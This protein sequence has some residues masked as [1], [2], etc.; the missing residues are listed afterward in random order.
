MKFER[1]ALD[2]RYR[3]DGRPFYLNGTQALVRLTMLE[4][5]RR[6]AQGVHTA[7]YASGYRGSPLGG[8]DQAMVRAKTFL[9]P[10]IV[11]QPGVNEDIAAT[12]IWG[13]QQVGVFGEARYDGVSALWYGKGPGVDRT[14]DVFKHGNLAGSSAQGGVLVVAGDDHTAKSSTT[15]HQSEFGLIDA[16][17]PILAPASIA[18]IMEYGLIGWELSRFTGLWCAIKVVTDVMDSSASITADPAPALVRPKIE[19]PPG[20]LSLRWP[21]D[22]LEQE[23]RL[24]RYKLPAALAFAR[25]NRLDRVII[26]APAAKLGIVTVGKAHTDT[27]QALRDLGIDEAR[28]AALGVR[29]YKV[30]MAWPLEPQGVRAFAEGLDQIVVV[31]EKRSLVEDQL[32]QH[33]YGAARP[34]LIVGKH[35]E[36]G[37]W[38]LPSNGDL[39]AKQIAAAIGPRI[40]ALRP[41]EDLAARLADLAAKTTAA[42][43]LDTILTRAP[44][45][46]P[47]CP[48]STSTKLPEGS[49]GFAGIGCHHLALP[50]ERGT[51]GFTHMGGEG[52]N[53]IGLSPFT[54]TPHT[55][56]NLGDGTYFH[57]GSLAIRAAVA[58]KVNITY[59]ILFNGAVAMTGG[60][61][62]DGDLTPAR[63]ARQML[64]EG[65]RQVVVVSDDPERTAA[66]VFEPG[67]RIVH[68]RELDAVQRELR[69][70]TGVT[71]LIYDQGCATELRRQRKRG[72]AVDP[73]V[74]VVIN[75]LVCE[76]CGDCS[77]QSSCLSVTPVETEF[78]R[79]RAIDLSTCNKDRSCL[80]GFCP[81]FVTVEGGR[82]RKPAV[83]AVEAA[84]LPEPQVGELDRPFSIMVTGIGGSGVVTVGA[85]LGFAAHMEGKAVH[86]MD[87]TGLA[88]KG[89]AVVSHVQLAPAGTVEPSAKIGAGSAD[90]LLACDTVVAATPDNLSRVARSA[91][92]VAN[93]HETIT[94]DFIRNPEFAV[95]R[96]RLQR[97]LAAAVESGAAVFFDAA[98]LAARLMG[99]AA[100]AALLMLGY[101]WQRGWLP[102]GWDALDRAIE[103]NGVAVAANRSAFAW[104]RRAAVD[105]PAVL[106]MA[107]AAR[108]SPPQ[109]RL[110]GST[111]ELVARRAGML[112]AYQDAAYARRYLAAVRRVE[113]AEASI[114]PGS[115][116]LTE[117]AAR[118]LFQLMA[119]KD[120]YEVARLYT[121]TGFLDG[122]KAQFEGSFRLRFHMAPPVLSRIDKATGR[123][124]K[125]TFG[126]AMIPLLRTLALAR[127]LRGT[128]LDVFGY[129]AERR[130][131]REAIDRY[132]AVLDEIVATLA[133]D[134]LEAA[135]RLAEAAQAIKGY[136]HVK[137]RNRDVAYAREAELLTAYRRQSNRAQDRVP[138]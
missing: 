71:V 46:C 8:F 122:L 84:A 6:Q 73:D 37:A 64:A 105:L 128:S 34:P 82:L 98:D 112:T 4:L 51:E 116:R 42:G 32:R 120:E 31:E 55:F 117:A 26:D 59:K 123:P 102:L 45:F 135:V 60:Q 50:M 93:S 89:G 61:A 126:P 69:E 16:S 47:G 63:I 20:A 23:A 92:I 62:M 113:A 10:D 88:Q 72:K 106:R 49:I 104:G 108:A 129:T 7:V 81:S 58:A 127:R 44:H 131:E 25:A 13:S 78:G 79:K 103:M 100:G 18:E 39:G 136:G 86:V 65:V 11:F 124:A 133:A 12:A 110:S 14:G 1:I 107:E 5:R 132:L 41:D 57:S 76:G 138:A 87:M 74:A 21:D 80:E 40:L 24:H 30:A 3:F 70:V 85:L 83:P 53:W 67:V 27:M 130:A 111:E 101:A 43:A 33:L 134:T 77:A 97:R 95:P 121:A 119:Y 54:A 118:S 94:G 56:Q 68:R 90:L 2:D 36:A 75:D 99:D 109:Q 91:H 125:Q 28:A 35:D 48:H 66:E 38:L 52:A 96:G 17:I 115:T 22:A 29:L 19:A 15:A 9:G 137:A 114:R